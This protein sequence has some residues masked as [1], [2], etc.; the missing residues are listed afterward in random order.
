MKTIQIDRDGEHPV[1]AQVADQV[2]DL[3]ASGALKPDTQLPSVRQLA[4]DLGV[5]LNTVARAYRLLESEGFLEILHRTGVTVAPPAI[6]VGKAQRGKL[7]NQLK[8]TISRLRQAGISGGEI[9][10][11]T[12]QTVVEMEKTGRESDNE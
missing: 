7:L 4:G 11:T 3:I 8:V 12:K 2:R 6:G 9:L 5:N 10:A 1:Y